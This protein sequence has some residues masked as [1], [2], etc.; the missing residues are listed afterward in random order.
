MVLADA[1]IV[2]KMLPA[3]VVLHAPVAKML[4]H[5]DVKPEGKVIVLIGVV[6]EI[7]TSGAVGAIVAAEAITASVPFCIKLLLSDVNLP[8]LGAVVPMGERL[9]VLLL[10]DWVAANVATVSEVDGKVK[11]VPSVPDRVRVL[12]SLK[13]LL[14]VPPDS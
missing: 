6:P 11:V 10:N 9:R 5:P 13:V 1:V 14:V 12:F 2:A 8:V 7:S 4:K 3:V